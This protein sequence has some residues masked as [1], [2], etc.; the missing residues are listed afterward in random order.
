[1]SH[2]RANPPFYQRAWLWLT[3]LLLGM[4]AA[5]AFFDTLAN[6]WLLV[7]PRITYIF[8]TA[9]IGIWAFLETLLKK[10]GVLW[11]TK[12]GQQIRIRRLGNKVR[13]ALIGVIVLLWLPRVAGI[14]DINLIKDETP[15]SFRFVGEVVDEND[16]AIPDAEII[17]T[18]KEGESE[19]LGYGRTMPT[20]E[21]DLAVKAKPQTTLWVTVKKDGVIRFKNYRIM[22]GNQKIV[23]NQ[24]PDKP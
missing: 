5:G 9:I 23:C 18:E 12:D 20:G 15:E 7:T 8:S 2:Y 1:M 3:F 10:R 4:L 11:L 17:I 24:K 13:G 19:R 6:T 14:F 21:F 22:L 16:E